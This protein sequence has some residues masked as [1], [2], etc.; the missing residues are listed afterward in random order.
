M[1]LEVRALN[2]RIRPSTPLAFRERPRLPAEDTLRR[3]AVAFRRAFEPLDGAL[4]RFLAVGA[5]PARPVFFSMYFTRFCDS[6]SDG[7]LNE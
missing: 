7:T 6:T 3:G 1:G 4:A 5:V 2:L